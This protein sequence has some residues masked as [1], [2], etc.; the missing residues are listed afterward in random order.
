MVELHCHVIL[1]KIFL[2]TLHV[3]RGSMDGEFITSCIMISEHAKRG[4]LI[5]EFSMYFV[6][7]DHIQLFRYEQ[8]PAFPFALDVKGGE[9]F[10]VSCDL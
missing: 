4:S 5:I 1:L 2:Q 8:Y 10:G 9:N 3:L 7:H 6:E